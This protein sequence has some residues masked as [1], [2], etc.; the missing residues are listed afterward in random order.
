[1]VDGGGGRDSWNGERCFSHPHILLRSLGKT[2][3]EASAP[4][5]REGLKPLP[6]TSVF[7]RGKARPA[8]GMATPDLTGFGG[9]VFSR[10]LRLLGVLK[11]LDRRVEKLEIV[12]RGNDLVNLDHFKFHTSDGDDAADLGAL[13]FV[14]N[15]AG[16]IA[17]DDH[18]THFI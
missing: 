13:I 17:A 18:I 6:Y 14:F 9:G 2:D 3:M 11:R 8:P 15:T 1:D 4:M 7:S 10:S 12:T 16:V 5:Q